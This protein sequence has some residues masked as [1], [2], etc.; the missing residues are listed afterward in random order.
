MTTL[1]TGRPVSA[2]HAIGACRCCNRTTTVAGALDEKTAY[3]QT[4][5][6]YNGYLWLPKGKSDAKT[7]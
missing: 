2:Y 4:C 7:L 5:C 1:D 3:C 6:K